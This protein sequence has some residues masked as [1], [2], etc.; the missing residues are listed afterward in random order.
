M[1]LAT[2]VAARVARARTDVDDPVALRGHPHVV[3][4]HD[5]RIARIDESLQ[6]HHQP[7]DVGGMQA[8]GRF[9]EDVQRVAALR[10]LQFGGE[11]D[12]LRLA[13]G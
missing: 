8:G 10:A 9:V 11:L 13:A 5:H 2:I 3:L 1:P 6:L 7:V 4:D 12:A